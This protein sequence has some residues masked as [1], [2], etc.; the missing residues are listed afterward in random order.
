MKVSVIRDMNE[1]EMLQKI[2]DIDSELLNLRFQ[3]K[4][5]KLDNPL[6]M[7]MLRR[8]VARIK[9]ILN[10]KL[11]GSLETVSDSVGSREGGR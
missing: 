2:E 11:T 10:E 7:R 4:T 1:S 3:V 9:T 5:G 6:R 8:D